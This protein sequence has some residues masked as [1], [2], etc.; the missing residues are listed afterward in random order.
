M[1]THKCLLSAL[2]LATA[3]A[4]G[5]SAMAADLPKEGKYRAQLQDTARSS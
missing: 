2:T 5:I 1:R 4:F 3:M